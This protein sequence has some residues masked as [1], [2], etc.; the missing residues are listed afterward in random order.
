MA[1]L[2]N[3]KISATYEGLFKTIDNA[4]ITASLK[5]LTD[6]SGNQSG[7]YVNNAG[8]FKVSNILEWGSLKDTG[9]GVTITRYV[10]STDGIENFDNNTSLPT[11]AAVKLYV[12]TKFATSDTLQEVL[13]FGNTTGGNDIVVS[14]S[15][16][17][18]FTDSS[19]ILMGAGSDLQ[20]YHDAGG[21]SYIKELGSGQFYIQAENF[22]FKSADGTSNLITA[23]VGGAVNLYYNDSKKFETTNLGAE[24]TGNLVVT[25]TITG[26]GG[27]FLPLAGGTM[28]GSTL[29]GDSVKS[30]YGTASDLEIY[31]DG[32]NSRIDETGTGSLILKTSALL[33]RNPADNSMIDAQSGGQVSLYYDS[34]IKL[35]TTN[36]GA[37]IT[38]ALSTT[39]NVS[40]GANATFVDNGKAVFGNSQD[41][42]IYHNTTTNSNYIQSNASRQLALNQDN[43]VVLNQSAN[44]VMISA[45]ADG[46]A[47][48]FFND[49]K[50]I[51]TVLAGAKVTGNLEVTG[52][53]TGA[54]GSF[55]PLIGGTM[56]G[57]TIHNDNVKSIYGTASDGLEIFHNGT[58]DF[59]VSKGTYNIFEANNHIFRNLA[60][61]EDY[62]K[63]IGNG[64][65][66]L[67]YNG[68]K[69]FETTN[70]G[71]SVTGDGVF[72]GN[73]SVPDSA[74]LYAGTSDDLSLTHNG[75]DSIIA[76]STGNLYIDQAAVTQSIFF[77]VSDANAL[78]TTALT[79]SRN[80]DASFG[81][82]VT[83]AGDLTVNGT[84][85]TV[86]S[87]TLAVVDPLIQLAKDNTANSLDIGL[88]GDYNDGTD[89]FLGLFSDA[90]DSNKFKLFKG[91]TVE[92]TTT[93]DIG[94]AGYVAADLQVAGL[95]ATNFVST[96]ITIADYIY[97]AGDGDTYIGFPAANEF[98][99]VAGGNNI[100]AGDVNA[101]Y[102]YYQGGVKLQ[103]T[104]TGV[105]ITGDVTATGTILSNTQLKAITSSG[106]VSGYFTDA[107][108]STFQ[109][110]H[111]S[112]QLQFLNGSNNIW[113]TED[114]SG[115]T[116]FGGNVGVNGSTTANVPITAT[117]GSGYE[118]VAYFKSAGT[119]INS[120]I[121]LF[122]TGTGSGAIN[123]TANN[124]LLQISG[125]TALTL[126]TSQNATFAGDV[127]SSSLTVSSAL[128]AGTSL[129]NTKNLNTGGTGSEQFYVAHS[130]S[131][132][133]LG[134]ARGVL[135]LG[136]GSNGTAVV[137]DSSGNATFGGNVTTG[138]SLLVN[139]VGNN[140][141]LTL[142]AN[143][144]NWVFTNVQASR[145]LEISDSDGTGTVLTLDT[146][147]NATFAASVGVGGAPTAGYNIDS[148]QDN[149]GYSIVGRHSSGGKVGIYN[150]TGDNGIGTINDYSMNFFTNNSAPQV[151]LTTAGNL[152]VGTNF[153]SAKLQVH[154]TNAG[155]PTVP[156]FIV[157]ESTTVGTEARL[158]F[159][160]NT[161]D[162]VGTNRYSYISTINT[163]GSNGQ[164]MV[165]ATNETGASA[166]ERMRITSGGDVL[167]SK[168]SLNIGVVGTEFRANGQSLFTANADNPVDLNRL[169]NDGAIALFR[170][171]GAIIGSIGSNTTGGNP[172]LD[173]AGAT[174]SSNIRFLTTNAERMRIDSSGNVGI[175]GSANDGYRL[176]VVGTSQDST[177]IS[178]TYVGVGAGA[179]KM[180]SNGAMAFGVDAAD[181]ATERMRI[182]SG[183]DVLVNSATAFSIATHD[184]NVI[185]TESFGINN[186]SNTSTFG[187]DRI[188][189]DSSNYYVLNAAAVG[190][191]LV[192]GATAWTAQSDESLKE[193]I[194]PLENVLDKIKDYRCVEYNLK[195]NNN[196]KI[197]FIAQDWENDFAPIVN[198]DDEGLLGMKYTE[199]IPVLLKAIQ[200]LK[201]EVDSLK[202][203]CNCKN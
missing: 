149:A 106:G 147:G 82:D 37:E 170:K 56:T 186:G 39:T 68:T 160:A 117:T 67:Y 121:S 89:R 143:T 42:E 46:A 141:S 5:E 176:Q 95:E 54:G 102:L 71:I 168:Q 81:R 158:G 183:G 17:I 110:K 58:N 119:N 52:T 62:A 138:Q 120:R 87:Q 175:G 80:A 10:T 169:T 188:H 100:I 171:D 190:V 76:N 19:K 21:D 13:S 108:N 135:T 137:I 125:T 123:S 107:V 177:T 23:N 41:L 28:T 129:I 84:T 114:G 118:D 105:S 140:S 24:V 51:E 115:N 30:I 104:S 16:D 70:T 194:K 38:G 196:K 122:P 27:S 187:L 50:R 185:T 47:N 167:F 159:A 29:H 113:L 44:K 78:D 184:P 179:L 109:I 7:L 182:T 197:G 193:N 126:D 166:V 195:A 64:A 127:L 88:Y 34:S 152:G 161:N 146:S 93:V 57:N 60:S 164:D 3:T 155:Q 72:T 181:G 74:F 97:H 173:I 103:T 33:V 111:A 101:A 145:N 98:K 151:T 14:D 96:D 99:L 86:N 85:T 79:I 128:E 199:T 131:D 75:T 133:V 112:G 174:G 1:T 144:G 91:T 189:F 156:L 40:V 203:K 153:V 31:H 90:S 136:T 124:L 201:A 32:S 73:V 45:V 148:I 15:D 53:I 65:V 69:K 139:G 154:S 9:T 77:R 130:G 61:N 35:S 132:V 48:L 142:G 55:L 92:P 116:T 22:R 200:E 198:K 150:S 172:L 163:S 20:I 43:F 191:K 49:T 11:T 202:Q 4:A 134:N 25:G 162:D 180:T 26:A 192:N 18:T 63:F 59:I 2:F 12:D 66:E 94:G 83:I 8:D 178:M 36:T 6:G 165:F 157:N